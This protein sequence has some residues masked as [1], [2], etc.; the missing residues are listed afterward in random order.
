[1]LLLLGQGVIPPQEEW[2]T[3]LQGESVTR[4][5]D[6]PIRRRRIEFNKAMQTDGA[7]RRR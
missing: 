3:R 5:G 7:S 4:L 2:S 6:L 1:M